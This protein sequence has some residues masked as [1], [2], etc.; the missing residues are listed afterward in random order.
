MII[1]ALAALAALSALPADAPRD[2]VRISTA[3]LPANTGRG[4]ELA[5]RIDAV[6]SDYCRMSPDVGPAHR[7][8]ECRWVVRHHIDRQ[9]PPPYR[10]EVRE[11]RRSVRG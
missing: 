11:A 4:P 3:N 10:A 1:T 6:V 5:R 9:L 2:E 7:E 8:M